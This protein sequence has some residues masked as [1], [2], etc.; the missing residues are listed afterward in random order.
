M[1]NVRKVG[2]KNQQ[3]VPFFDVIFFEKYR[4]SSGMELVNNMAWP[5]SHWVGSS[6]FV[7]SYYFFQIYWKF[8]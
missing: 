7:K 4:S 5:G 8:P 1:M 3:Y 6:A 2:S